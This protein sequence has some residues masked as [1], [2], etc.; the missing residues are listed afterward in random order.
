MLHLGIP[1]NSRDTRT[2]GLSSP[3]RGV[4]RTY[5]FDEIS[6]TPLPRAAL[7]HEQTYGLK[8]AHAPAVGASCVAIAVPRA[9]E[10][11]ALVHRRGQRD[12]AHLSLRVDALRKFKSN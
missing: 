7:R 6:N 9:A 3:Q 5:S 1:S 8:R 2:R 12:L 11:G 4:I 10:D